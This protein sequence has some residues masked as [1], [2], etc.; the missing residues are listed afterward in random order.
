MSP[1]R[2]DLFFAGLGRPTGAFWPVAEAQSRL[3]AATF[4]GTYRPPSA[5]EVRRRARPVA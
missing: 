3:A 2:H 4:A 1:V 5:D